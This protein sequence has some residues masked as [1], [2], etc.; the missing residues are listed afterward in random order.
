MFKKKQTIKIKNVF[1]AIIRNKEAVIFIS[2]ITVR[3][4]L[5]TIRDYPTLRATDLDLF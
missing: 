1:C 5:W 3:A 2:I 4:R